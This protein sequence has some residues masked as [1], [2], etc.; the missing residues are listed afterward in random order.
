MAIHLTHTAP[1]TVP[2][3]TLHPAL[4]EH[5][6][7]TQ[8]QLCATGEIPVE[9]VTRART[10]H[11]EELLKDREGRLS[12]LDAAVARSI[13]EEQTIADDVEAA[14]D[15]R[16]SFG[17][18]ASDAIA[19]FGGSWTFI[20]IFAGFLGSWMLYNNAQGGKGFDPY[21]FILLNLI[22][23]TIAAIQAPIIMMSQGRQEEKDR[24]RARND[25]QVNLKAELEIRHLHD[26]LDHLHRRQLETLKDLRA[27]IEGNPPA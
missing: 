22:L 7:A 23:S 21:P 14:Y 3:D 15:A 6:R 24:L 17:D 11:I 18:R 13:A 27:V 9:V 10:E 26:K 4:A 25:Y 19:D 2:L 16:R 1:R 5:L 8:P 12:E 20:L